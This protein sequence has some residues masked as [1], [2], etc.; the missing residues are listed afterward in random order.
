MEPQ[1]WQIYQHYKNKHHYKI[2]A[3][4]RHSETE[5]WMVVY[6]ALYDNPHSQFY[7]R[8]MELFVDEVE[9]EWNKM[10]RFCFVE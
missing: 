5:E 6:E 3:I 9:Y 2:I 10:P 1:I 7:A 4:A 8:P